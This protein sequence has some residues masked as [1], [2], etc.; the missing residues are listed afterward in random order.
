MKSLSR[1]CKY[2]IIGAGASGLAV[3][4]NFRQRGIPFDCVEREP[5]LGGLWNEDLAAG[6]VYKTTHMVSSKEFTWFEDYPMPEDYPLYPGHDLALDYLKS[7][8]SH[9]GVSDSIEFGTSVKSVERSGDGWQV[10]IEGEERPRRYT[11]I[12]MASGHHEVPRM[13]AIP[14]QFYGEVL[15]SSQYSGPS[16]LTGK[17]VLVIG[18]GNSGGDIAVDATHHAASIFHSMRHG[19][20]FVPR[21]ML[22]VPIDDVVDFVEIFRL[23]RWLRQY[24]YAAGHWLTVG[25]NWRYG[26][27]TPEHRILDTHPTVN[28]EIPALVAEGRLTVK[29][30]VEAFSGSSVRFTDGSEEEVDLVVYA[31]GYSL[32]FPFLDQKQII[33]GK[34][35][36]KLALNIFHPDWDDFFAVGLV[37]ANGSMWRL[38]DRQAQLIAG[39]IQARQFRPRRADKLR[40]YLAS[41]AGLAADGRP[42]SGRFMDTARHSLEA[43]YHQYQRLMKRLT[44]KLGAAI[45]RPVRIPGDG[46]RRK[47]EQRTAKETAR[48][49]VKAA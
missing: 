24:L 48:E 30:D 9:F 6:R 43:D 38:A 33:D 18:A 39:Y 13:P 47:P 17:R 41:L 35:H 37:N 11:G 5:D 31:T 15:H 23:P 19:Y 14:G 29:P 36:S 28:S 12:V 16:Q 49:E 25:P 20:Y 21:F 10:S 34:G 27:P 3:A 32:N 7:Y 8:A 46:Q 42:I 4:K 44:R 22:G 1:E 2:C 45:T 40:K 26:L